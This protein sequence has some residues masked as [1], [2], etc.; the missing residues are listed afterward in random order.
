MV[1]NEVEENLK[2]TPLFAVHQALGAR[3]VPFGGWE[4]PVQY[5]GVIDEHKAVRERAGLFDVSHMGEFELTGPGAL[6]LI[7]K[8]S[9]NNARRLEV[10]DIQYSLMCNEGGTVVDDILI[11]RLGAERYWL[12]VNAGNTTKD[13]AWVSQHAEGMSDV[14]VRNITDDVALLALQG[15]MAEEILQRLTAQP[16]GEIGYYKAMTGV[17]IANMETLV[18]SRTGYT[19]EDGFE[20]YLK[21]QEAVPMWEALLAAGKD[22]GVLPAGLGARDTLRFEARLPLYGHE[23][24]E[25]VNPYEAGLGFFVKLKKGADFIG[26]EALAAIKET[27]TSRKLVGFTMAGRGIPRQGYEISK[28]GQAVGHVTTGSFSPTTG[29]NIGLGYMPPDLSTVGSEFDVVIRGTPVPARVVETP[30]VPNR[31]KR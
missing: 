1:L 2:R 4:M 13:W 11:Y 5:S 15:P 16:L 27:G 9:T 21:P 25:T 24:D 19:G 7:Q 3:L 31:S 30:F 23:I 10:G 17:T 14:A 20:L 28:D 8:V 12:V 26:R 22:A 29:Q 6:A 18:I